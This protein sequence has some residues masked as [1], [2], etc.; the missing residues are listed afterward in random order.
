MDEKDRGSNAVNASC[1]DAEGGRGA[2][3]RAGLALARRSLLAVAV[4]AL[5]LTTDATAEV[6]RVDV[7]SRTDVENGRSYGAA[8]A[9]ELVVGRIHFA[10]DPDH[11]RNRVIVDLDK[12]PRNAAGYVELSADLAILKPKD[13]ASGSGTL[14]LDVVNRGGKTVLGAFNRAAPDGYGDGWLMRLGMTVVWVGWEFDV[15]ERDGAIRIDVPSAAGGQATVRSSLTPNA[16]APSVPFADLAP[17]APVDPRSPASTLTVREDALGVPTPI[18]R[19]RWTQDGTSVTLEGGFAAGPTYELTYQ[20]AHAP[21]AGLGFAAVRDTV[22]W[23]KHAADAPVRAER[24]IAFGASQSGRYLRTFLYLGFNADEEN[25]RVF[26]GV[27]A[28][29]AGAA[30]LDLNRRGATPISL[31]LFDATSFPFADA[32]LR[33]PVTGFT[34]GTLD[35]SRARGFEPKIFYTNTGVEY[36]GGGRSAALVHTTPDGATDL[37]LPDNVRFYFF[38]GTQHVPGRFP[39]PAAGNA[40]QR[41]NPTDYGYAMRAL[42]V[43]MAEWAR[44]GK[45]PPPSR[46]PRLADGTLVRW[47]EIT[48]PPIPGVRSPAGLRPAVRGANPLAVENGAPGTPLPTLVPQT[49]RDGN[50]LAG[51][52]L[53]D[54][55]VPL[56]TY[57]GWNFR[58]AAIGGEGQLLPLIGSYVPFPWVAAEASGE[59]DPRAA[60]TDRYAS[61]DAYLERVRAAADGLVAG[62][63]LR[64][65]D[66]PAVV[67]RAGEHWDL[68]A[69]SPQGKR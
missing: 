49:D 17:Y 31:G 53:P 64:A 67:Q 65:E 19:E 58:N 4:L 1:A 35:N 32:A 34:E 24:A 25:R 68:L 48:F 50:E 51:I 33:D 62:R 18:A 22:A 15:P 40:E 39:P 52:R 45:A 46:H 43:A 21:V 28:H 3:W 38:A 57:T 13:A 44:D 30:R 37:T 26:D 54:I 47:S 11:E 66:V 6:V 5:T 60:I 14:L 59:Q 8:G 41:A 27:I 2:T 23:L 16:A 69:R 9:Y 29:I 63:Y 7:A 42:L 56:A 55:E 20:T 61:R 36:W 12:A 10:V